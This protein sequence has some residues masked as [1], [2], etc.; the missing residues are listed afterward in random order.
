MAVFFILQREKKSLLKLLSSNKKKS[1]PSPPSSPTLE[2][3]Q[4]A[5]GDALHGA[6]GHE[7]VSSGPGPGPGP[8]VSSEP[9]SAA[10]S[11]SSSPCVVFDSSHR[12][13][14]A[15]D[16]VCAPIAPP[17]RQACSSLSSQQQDARPIVCERYGHSDLLV[18][19][20]SKY[21]FCL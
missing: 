1:R 20:T 10:S 13:N 5:A 17:P 4:T 9:D 3:E 6:M 16:I 15:L 11:S 2:V 14:T 12:K 7:A 8:A 21:F 18:V 19:T